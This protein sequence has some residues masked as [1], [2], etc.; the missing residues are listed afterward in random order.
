MENKTQPFLKQV[1]GFSRGNGDRDDSWHNHLR[2]SDSPE[3]PGSRNNASGT[4]HIRPEVLSC[5]SLPYQQAGF[6]FLA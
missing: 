4:G 5:V 1:T 2:I 6:L 3:I